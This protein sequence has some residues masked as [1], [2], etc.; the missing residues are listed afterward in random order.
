MRD[1]FYGKLNYVNGN[2][3]NITGF[4]NELVHRRQEH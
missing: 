3:E 1:F 2:M 4:C